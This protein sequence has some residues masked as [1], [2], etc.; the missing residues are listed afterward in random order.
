MNKVLKPSNNIPS[1]LK[2]CDAKIANALIEKG[3]Y[4]FK[5]YA[6]K[7]VKTKLSKIY[8]NKCAFCETDSTDGARLQVEHYRPKA[9][10]KEDTTHNG[11]YWLGYEWTN[12]LYACSIC[13]R[14]KDTHFPLNTGGIRV[15][16]APP[17]LNNGKINK[18]KY[19]ITDINLVNEKPLI[20]NPEN[21]NFNP[22]LHF[23]ITPN[24]NIVGISD[25]GKKTIEICKLN[26][27]DVSRK[28]IIEEH[29]DN[30]IKDF[31]RF[32]KNEINQS[33]LEY[34]I[35]KEIERIMSRF[36]ENK[37]YSFLAKLMLKNF[38]SFFSNRFQSN[39]KV[40]LKK[41]FVSTIRNIII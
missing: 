18:T 39:E 5:G 2:K 20:L 1:S 34:G 12:L 17:T 3:K 30:F 11:Y 7:D 24:G 26:R 36:V 41:V 19:K 21:I 25:E 23:I 8:N 35:Q 13:N 33:Q 10:V 40:I 9:K 38:D 15:P 14:S 16:D 27:L 4:D 29:L 6:E 31:D 32:S 28:K 37:P 22:E